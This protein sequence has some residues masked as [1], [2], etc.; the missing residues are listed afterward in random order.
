MRLKQLYKNFFIVL[1]VDILLLAGSFYVAYLIRFEFDIPAYFL[2]AFYRML[3]FVLITKIAFF[4]FFD[5][6][7]GMWRYTS[8]G[9]LFN[10][11]KAASV[12]TLVITFYVLIRYHFI[13]YS[14][15]VFLIDWCLTILFIAGFRLVVRIYFET[16]GR[17]L[18]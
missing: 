17:G 14:R 11:I 3:P 18:T 9:D 12:S 7:R 15:S 1:G 2:A 16:T 5:L 13:G 4:Y 8:I 6:Y 10:I